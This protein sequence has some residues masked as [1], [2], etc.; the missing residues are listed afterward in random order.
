MQYLRKYKDKNKWEKIS[1]EEAIEKT[2]R[3]YNQPEALIRDLESGKLPQ[4]ET[5]WAIFKVKHD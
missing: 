4:L 2:G 3:Y 5:P 1:R